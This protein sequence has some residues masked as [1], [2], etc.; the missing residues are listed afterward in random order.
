MIATNYKEVFKRPPKK[1]PTDPRQ[2]IVGAVLATLFALAGGC[3]QGPPKPEDS[4]KEFLGA[5]RTK[6][7][8]VAWSLLS[9]KTQ[10]E[11]KRRAALVAKAQDTSPKTEPRDLLFGQL[12]LMALRIPESISVASPIDSTVSLRVSLEKG[13]TATIEMIREGPAWKVDLFRSLTPVPTTTVST[14][15]AP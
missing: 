8:K 10:A 6:R 12:E 5:V 1:D 15:T 9:A 2:R 7:A 3:Q 4:L 11:L 14:S 13:Q